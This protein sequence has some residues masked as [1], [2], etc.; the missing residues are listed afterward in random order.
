MMKK[1]INSLFVMLCTAMTFTACTEEEGTMPGNDSQ[2]S[3]TIYQYTPGKGYNP[4]NDV[5]IRLAT[6]NK[7]EAVFYLVE[8]TTEKADFIASNGEEAYAD[9]VISNGVKVNNTSDE[10]NTD[11]IITG[12]LGKNSITAVAIAGNE[13]RMSETSFFGYVWTPKYKGI[14]TSEFFNESW[15]A[16][17][18]YEKDA[19]LYRFANCWTECYHAIF[20]WKGNDVLVNNGGKFETGQEDSRY[21]MISATQSAAGYT[22]KD[23]RLYFT[24]T[25]TVSAGSFGEFSDYFEIKEEIQ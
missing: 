20:S 18:E 4:E 15:E 11:I 14:Y 12:I 25:W 7:T 22:E 3:V 8:K 16:V 13:K 23:Q 6:N 21:G 9:R 19:N 24:Y 5:C 1:Y 17:L 10:K 2:P